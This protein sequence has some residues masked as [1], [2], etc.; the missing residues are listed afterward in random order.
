[1]TIS[2]TGPALPPSAA[3]TRKAMMN[4]R[5]PAAL[6]ACLLP[7]PGLCPAADEAVTFEQHVRPVLK[8]YCLDCHGGGERLK[9]KLD[10]RLRR[11]AVAGGESG[12]AVVPGDPAKSLLV[13]RLKAGEMPPTEKKVPADKV[14]AIE[15]WVAAGA[16]AGR[17]EPDR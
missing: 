9:G 17:D 12:P 4:L 3:T 16:P 5:L 13:Q 14:A 6:A 8:A 10:L 15:R 2:L 1:G 7:F 11:F